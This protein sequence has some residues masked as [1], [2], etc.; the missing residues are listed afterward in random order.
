M[1][2]LQWKILL[3]LA[4]TAIGIYGI[5]PPEKKIKLGLDLKGGIHLVAEVKLD[6]ALAGYT[7]KCIESLRY[8]LQEKNVP[9]TNIIRQSNTSFLIQGVKS[10]NEANVKKIMERYGDWDLGS[11][12]DGKIAGSLRPAVIQSKS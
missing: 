12:S 11:F 9:I 1:K 4:L 7:D 3:V 6:E 8:E 10:E 5:Y 2:N